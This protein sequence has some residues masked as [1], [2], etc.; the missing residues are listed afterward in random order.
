[1]FAHVLKNNFIVILLINVIV[2]SVANC[3]DNYLDVLKACLKS[4][5]SSLKAWSIEFQMK[6]E[7][8]ILTNEFSILM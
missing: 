2:V 3:Y 4:D 8:S 1:M 6:L 7:L 5:G